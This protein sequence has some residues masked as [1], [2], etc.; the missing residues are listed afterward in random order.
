ML[1]A[2]FASSFSLSTGA[3]RSGLSSVE[4]SLPS[5][6]KPLMTSFC[7]FACESVFANFTYSFPVERTSFTISA[8]FVSSADA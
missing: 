7:A 4:L 8:R 1:V 3:S 5:L 2:V 6:T